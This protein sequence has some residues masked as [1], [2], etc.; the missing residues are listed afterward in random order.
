MKRLSKGFIFFL[1]LLGST[2]FYAQKY[3]D[4]QWKKI[5]ESSK[6]GTLKSN[7]PTILDIQNHA[8]KDNNTL[9]LIRSLKA[10]FSIVNQTREDEQNNAVSKFFSKLSDIEKQLKGDEKNYL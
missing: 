2:M 6:K 1:L 8:M 5:E 4:E 10:E 7:L 9:Q 3:Y